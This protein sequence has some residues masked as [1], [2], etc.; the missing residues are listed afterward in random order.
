MLS[1]MLRVGVHVVSLWL[2][3]SWWSWC[4]FGV[5]VCAMWYGTLKTSIKCQHHAHMCFNMP[6]YTGT[7]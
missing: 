4:V 5:C 2:W 1:A 7:F 3:C 6:A